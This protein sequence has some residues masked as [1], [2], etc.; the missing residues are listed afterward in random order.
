MNDGE[1][2]VANG[3]AGV[4]IVLP[5]VLSQLQGAGGHLMQHQQVDMCLVGSDR[6]TA[7]GDVCNKIGTYL[8]ALAAQHNNVPFYVA[9]PTSTIDWTITDGIQQI[10]IEQRDDS[11]ITCIQGMQ[12]NAAASITSVPTGTPVANYAFD[13]TPAALVSGLITEQGVFSTDT[14]SMQALKQRG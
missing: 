1:T 11:E 4:D 6:T 13:V 10:P 8:K 14:H 5:E 2:V 12:H 3:S 9:L 7:Q